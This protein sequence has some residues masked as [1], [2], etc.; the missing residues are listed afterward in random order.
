MQKADHDFQFEKVAI[1][2][3]TTTVR[4][5]EKVH[6][7]N[8]QQLDNDKISVLALCVVHLKETKTSEKTSRSL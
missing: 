4:T 5:P 7:S 3:K 6:I 1:E 2:V 8:I